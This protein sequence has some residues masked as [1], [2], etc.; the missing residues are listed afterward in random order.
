[1]SEVC[2]YI[3]LNLMKSSKSINF[4]SKMSFDI[5]PS[6]LFSHLFFHLFNIHTYIGEVTYN[7]IDNVNTKIL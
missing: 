2:S 7:F 5:A 3:L 1:M 4:T 6:A